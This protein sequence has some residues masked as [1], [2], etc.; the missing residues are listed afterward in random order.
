MTKGDTLSYDQ[1]KII[2]ATSFE[3]QIKRNL[4][5]NYLAL[6]CIKESAIQRALDGLATQDFT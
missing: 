3:C 1:R 4:N 5:S 2:N 6:P